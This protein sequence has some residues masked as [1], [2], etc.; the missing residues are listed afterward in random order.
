M[1][2]S[3]QIPEIITYL[4]S[5]NPLIFQIERFNNFYIKVQYVENPGLYWIESAGN[6]VGFLET[7]CYDEHDFKRLL[8]DWSNCNYKLFS[9]L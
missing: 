6:A 2:I 4:M 5:G 1:K 8:K 9:Q 3:D 7:M